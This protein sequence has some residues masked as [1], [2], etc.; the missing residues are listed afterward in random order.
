[1]ANLLW[2]PGKRKKGRVSFYA[3]FFDTAFYIQIDPKCLILHFRVSNE[4][5]NGDFSTRSVMTVRV[6][7]VPLI[8]QY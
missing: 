3:K 7:T 6:I 4:S 8:L 5:I 1:M 2:R